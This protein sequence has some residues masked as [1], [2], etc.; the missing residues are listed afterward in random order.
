MATTKLSAINMALRG[1]GR[2]PVASVDDPDLDSAMALSTIEQVSIDIQTQGWWF[3]KEYNW[4]LSGSTTGEVIV[5]NNALSVL[6]EGANRG[7]WVVI[8]GNK[9]YDMINH[10]YD[11]TPRLVDGKIELSFIIE[12]E[13]EQTPPVF[14]MAVAY[15]A[16]RMFAQDLEVDST[17]WQFQV[18]DENRAMSRLERE[19]A[20]H[21]RRNY[22]SDNAEAASAIAQMGGPNSN[23]YASR[24]FPRRDYIGS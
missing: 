12:L 20:R 4:K 5:P 9:L 18:E 19:E 14:R 21:R 23:S 17:R 11:L 13:F 7:N 16:R 10:T 3:N 24:I 1:I 6:P 2:D 8:R 15:V 22:L